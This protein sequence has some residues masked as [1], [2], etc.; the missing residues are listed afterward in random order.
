MYN[1]ELSFCNDLNSLYPYGVKHFVTIGAG[2][3]NQTS[4]RTNAD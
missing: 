2:I 4:A 3:G 1:P